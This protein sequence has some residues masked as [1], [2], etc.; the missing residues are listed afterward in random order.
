M[1]VGPS[2]SVKYLQK[3]VGPRLLVNTSRGEC[4]CVRGVCVGSGYG[5]EHVMSLS[6]VIKIAYQRVAPLQHI[7]QSTLQK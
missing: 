4:G 2:S 7:E 3:I 5:C 6:E 1:C